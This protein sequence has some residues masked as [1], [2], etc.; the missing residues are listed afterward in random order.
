MFIQIVEYIRCSTWSGYLCFCVC[1]LFSQQLFTIHSFHE[2]LY[3]GATFFVCTNFNWPPDIVWTATIFTIVTWFYISFMH[4]LMKWNNHSS[5]IY[6]MCSANVIFA[7][8][9]VFVLTIWIEFIHEK[10][11][12][13]I[14]WHFSSCSWLLTNECELLFS[15]F[16]KYYV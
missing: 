9:I 5:F 12:Y 3:S 2:S 11:Q 6:Y 7:Y 16:Q 1:V 15:F 14:E 10:N 8:F 13:L 4:N